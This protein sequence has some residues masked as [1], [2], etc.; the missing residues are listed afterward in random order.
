MNNFSLQFS[1][2]FFIVIV[3]YQMLIF[4]FRFVSQFTMEEDSDNCLVSVYPFNDEV[5]TL[6]ETPV[7]YR[8]D[9]NS[10]ETLGSVSS[11]QQ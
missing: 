11:Y 8:I 10:L 2:E 1:I 4:I 9:P 5:Y 6:T 7:M 3:V